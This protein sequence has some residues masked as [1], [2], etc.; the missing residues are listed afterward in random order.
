[1]SDTRTLFLARHGQTD[2]NAEGRLQGG[3]DT[4]LNAQ[5]EAQ[6]AAVAE[7]LAGETQRR[8]V[9]SVLGVGCSKER[10]REAPGRL[11]YGLEDVGGDGP[12]RQ[13]LG[14]APC[15]G[16]HGPATVAQPKNVSAT[17]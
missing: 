2:W 14:P 17:E 15:R 8:R 13:L 6:A 3:R 5:G 11:G 7:R 16:S 4:D 1:M 12:P 10:R 9:L